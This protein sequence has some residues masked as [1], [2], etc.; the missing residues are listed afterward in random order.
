M[1]TIVISAVNIR[2]G[3]TLTILRQCLTFLSDHAQQKGWRVVAIV[4]RRDLCNYPSI[5]YIELPHV[6]RSWGRRL[7]CE[8]VTMHRISKQLSPI[9]LWV[10]LHDTTPRVFAKRQ[11]VY[12]QTSFPFLKWN[13]RDLRFDSKIVLFALFTR[14]AYRINIHRNYRLIVQAEWLRNGFAHM[15]GIPASH[16]I[17]APPQSPSMA[18]TLNPTREP[19]IQFF[20]PSTPDCHKNFELACQAAQLLECEIGVD[21][22][23][24]IITVNGEENSYARWLKQQWGN[25]KSI[26][27]NGFM[28]KD[29]LFNTYAQSDALI[30]PSRVETWGLAISEFGSYNKPMLLADLPYAHETSAGCSQV[31]FFPSD[32]AIALKDLMK[33]LIQG[34]RSMLS[35]NPKREIP[36]PTTQN[37]QELFELL[38]SE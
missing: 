21:K 6:A 16:F 3:G 5:E 11:A 35:P 33:R 37:W 32:N 38:M 2:K 31:S 22:F 29:Q 17:V 4:H 25:V 13:Y 10:S 28:S 12:C 30:Y 14:F 18:S 19:Y 8:Y 15:F 26:R 24:L 34:D 7:W 23:R 27:F 36:Q 1:R 20:F 9:D